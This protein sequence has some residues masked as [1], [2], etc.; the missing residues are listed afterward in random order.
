MPD[1]SSTD[2]SFMKDFNA[3]WLV[4][5]VVAVWGVFISLDSFALANASLITAALISFYKA[6]AETHLRS[7][8][9][10]PGIFAVAALLIAALLFLG[11]WFS[12]YREHVKN[13]QDRISS[14]KDR[15]IENLQGLPQEIVSLKEAGKTQSDKADQK[16]DD[17]AKQ[18]GQLERAIAR[19]DQDLVDIAKHELALKFEPKVL[20]ESRASK[21]TLFV[22][23]YGD[24]GIQLLDLQLE[25]YPLVDEGTGKPKFTAT[26]LPPR[27]WDEA[28]IDNG[29]QTK[30]IAS[31]RGGTL[32]KVN[33][34][35]VFRTNDAKRYRLAFT[36]IFNLKE[37]KIASVSCEDYVP[38]EMK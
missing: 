28:R 25:G 32:A 14:E 13:E 17:L 24:T 22:T 34:N 11:I 33:G 35:I 15:K 37:G 1:Y 29:S 2:P 3:A 12:H 30:I 8:Q 18:N 7:K 38:T 26:S 5:G 27:T 6:A 23:N 20:V 19:K 4:A 21:D 36:W 9:R 16:I 10:K 31:A